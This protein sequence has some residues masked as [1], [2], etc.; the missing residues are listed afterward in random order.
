MSVR[1]PVGPTN[2]ADHECAIGRGL[3][4]IRPR[5]CIAGRFLWFALRLEEAALAAKGT[6][7]TFTAI[8]RADL[9]SVTLGLPPLVEQKRIV[10]KVEELLASVNAARGRLAR[11]P[12]V[13]KRFRQAVLEEAFAGTLSEDWALSHLAGERSSAPIAPAE[14]EGA[15][16]AIP[17]GWVRSYVGA[18]GEIID[19]QPSHRTP[20][21]VPGG[22]PYVGIGDID[23]AGNIALAGARKVAASVLAEHRAR[24]SLRFGDLVFGKIGTLGRPTALPEPF[25]YALSANLVLVQPRMHCLPKYLLLFMQSPYIAAVLETTNRATSQP[26]FGI[27]RI[28]NI[29]IPVPSLTEQTEI[30]RRVEALFASADTIEKRVAATTARAG[31]LTQ[32]I[33]AKAFRGELAFP[34]GDATED[35][36]PRFPLARRRSRLR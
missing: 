29:A 19:P 24:Y 11:V 3:A 14:A 18:L 26:A 1:A 17:G 33:L 25:D 28:R 30:V 23:S 8:S 9:E 16:M 21:I 15:E 27:K 35:P 31:R 32:A 4:A 13:L 22:V 2:V 20:P 5:E 12:A 34:P 6:G 10:A 7:S 36:Q